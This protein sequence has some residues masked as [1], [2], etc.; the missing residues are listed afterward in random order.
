MPGEKLRDRK[1]RVTSVLVSYLNNKEKYQNELRS[2][3]NSLRPFEIKEQDDEEIVQ[4]YNEIMQNNVAKD[5]ALGIFSRYLSTSEEN[6]NE[7]IYVRDTC[8]VNKDLTIEL[9]H[10]LKYQF[11]F[12]NWTLTYFIACKR[13][14]ILY[15]LTLPNV[16][17][18][19]VKFINDYAQLAGSD[20]GSEALYQFIAATLDDL[21]KKL[22]KA[23]NEK[24]GLMVT[25]SYVRTMLDCGN[26]WA[27]MEM[28]TIA[29]ATIEEI[30]GQIFVSLET[31]VCELTSQM[32]RSLA[33]NFIVSQK[34]FQHL[35][36]FEQKLAM[37]YIGKYKAENTIVASQLRDKLPLGNKNH[38]EHTVFA[39]EANDDVLSLD[40]LT[41]Y[42]HSGTVVYVNPELE[43]EMLL[44]AASALLQQ[45]LAIGRDTYH[46]MSLNAE[47]LDI[48]LKFVAQINGENTNTFID[49]HIVLNTRLAAEALCKQG[50]F[51]TNLCLNGERKVVAPELSNIKTLLNIFQKNREYL[52]ENLMTNAENI[53]VALQHYVYFET[54]LA[55][56]LE[57]WSTSKWTDRFNNS[58]PQLD[59]SALLNILS[60]LNNKIIDAL[61]ILASTD[62]S[63]K[64]DFECLKTVASGFACAS[65]ENRTL[66]NSFH[67]N[68]FA[69][70]QYLVN[71]LVGKIESIKSMDEQECK[72]GLLEIQASILNTD[73]TKFDEA[74]REVS[75][76]KILGE[77][78][79]FQISKDA[80]NIWVDIEKGIAVG[81]I[82]NT[83]INVMKYILQLCQSN[84]ALDYCPLLFTPIVMNTAST[85]HFQMMAGQQGGT[86]GTEGI[87][88]KSEDSIPGYYPLLAR[89]FMVG[90]KDEI[91]PADQKNMPKLTLNRQ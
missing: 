67:S 82:K 12:I 27:A 69:K 76:K 78:I 13:I 62:P 72:L 18:M 68:I 42:F 8:M 25:E 70:Y 4:L 30:S 59:L 39:V 19:A 84:S 41:S 11:D 73:W 65:G 87:R 24:E 77:I 51:A 28:P 57:N 43:E 46:F 54:V 34:W 58:V 48:A 38:Y 75:I 29:I 36:D 63:I 90:N 64:I 33:D 7:F 49:R 37:F 17:E 89:L 53:R 91:K 35:T 81:N 15:E 32:Q 86:L 26:K 88:D 45:S 2:D 6:P 60:H 22:Y 3:V 79:T 85:F 74:C 52:Q 9:I 14:A 44:G 10:N 1:K 55:E 16:Y 47:F 61:K 80:H 20:Q 56:L 83:Y 31:P 40:S 50:I 66:I 5:S 21:V 71:Q 23:F